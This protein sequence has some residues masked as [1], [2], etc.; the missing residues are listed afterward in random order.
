MR[1][2][3]LRAW[4]RSIATAVFIA[5]A[6][7]LA[8]GASAQQ[9][10]DRLFVFGDSY[11]D[12]TLSNKPAFNSLAP[13]GL[14]L[15]FW[16][17]YPV[18]LAGNLHIPQSIDVA[19]GGATASPTAGTPSPLIFPPVI[20]P[21]NLPQQVGGFFTTSPSFSFGAND[22][23]TIN[24]G[25]NDIR[26]IFVN[27]ATG[28][29]RGNLAAGYF[30]E[31]L[32]ENNANKFAGQTVKY[33]MGGTSGLMG[34]TDLI[35][36]GAHNFVLG[37][38]SSI[39]R[40]PEL[41]LK[42][43][44]SVAAGL[45]TQAQANDI[46]KS[47]D[48]YATA[49][50][51]GMQ[52]A[53]LP[54]A[55]AGNRFFLFDLGRLGDAVFQNPAKYGFTGTDGNPAFS[56]GFMCPQNGLPATLPNGASNPVVAVCGATIKNPTNNNPD[57]SKYYFGPDGLH[58]TNAGFDLVGRYMANIVE[59]PS[60]IGVQPAVVSA[61][62][63]GFV[64]SV[65]GRLDATHV[66]REAAGAADSAGD[67]P[68]G[69]GRA[70]RSRAP[71]ADPV[72]SR[73][74]AYTMGSILG[75]NQGETNA[76]VGFDYDSRSGTVGI[77]Y[78]INR[79]LIFGIAGNYTTTNAGLDNRAGIDVNAT[80]GAAYLSYATRHAFAEGLAAY[81][82]HDVDLSRP[83]VL[84]ND[85]VHSSADAAS[86]AAAVRGGYLFDVGQLRAGPIA[87]LTF[88]HSRVD[89]YSEN[90]DELLKYN[91]SAQ[92]LDSVT[93][94]LGLRFLAPFQAGGNIVVPYL[95]VM[96]EQQFGDPTRTLTASLSQAPLLPILTPISNFGDSTY[97]RVE[98]GVTF[99]IGPALSATVNGATA[100]G[101]GD[102]RDFFV[103]AG[104][105][106]RF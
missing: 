85:Q 62:T 54:Y 73:L 76:L 104:L 10:F 34:V 2:P 58:L 9:Q 50:F 57:Q 3:C 102:D 71:L 83:G 66:A 17:V 77:E 53:L 42:L 88:L 78:S 46:A 31:L 35:N 55:Q 93:F 84:P 18:S 6:S 28:N 81:S 7:G 8:P 68:M 26:E 22:L 64:Q 12:L 4:A 98:G 39:S 19:V 11:A 44:S 99:Q 51:N 82:S 41:Q 69:L 103:N 43:Q 56:P 14:G 59:A 90:G 27:T 92:T 70:D 16:N 72:A 33:A 48:A 45:L 47:A 87:G 67:G 36:A 25:G 30:D 49:Y 65:L 52:A 97:G 61:T 86:V 20:A 79:N 80:Q 101:R 95:N 91:V 63:S 29:A 38:F 37:E 13:P 15:S 74:T 89:G 96:L 40:L 106:Y 60:T 5:A 21:G 94:N 32:T 1:H 105:N 23:V 24:I 75:G 100:F